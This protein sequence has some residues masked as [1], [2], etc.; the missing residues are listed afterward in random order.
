LTEKLLPFVPEIFSAPRIARCGH[1][2]SRRRWRC[3]G[4]FESKIVFPSAMHAAVTAEQFCD[5]TNVRFIGAIGS[6]G[7]RWNAWLATPWRPSTTPA[8]CNSRK[9]SRRRI[10]SD[11]AQGSDR[12]RLFEQNFA[13]QVHALRGTESIGGCKF[14]RAIARCKRLHSFV[15]RT[16]SVEEQS[17]LAADQQMV[18]TCERVSQSSAFALGSRPAACRFRSQFAVP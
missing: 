8:C 3:D 11:R 18:L 1:T 5:K 12:L 16:K 10:R 2:E 15:G 13:R 7:K 14:A 6:G 17:A 4:C 9:R